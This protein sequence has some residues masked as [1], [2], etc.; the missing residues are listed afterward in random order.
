MFIE[1]DVQLDVVHGVLKSI[2]YAGQNIQR[3]ADTHMHIIENADVEMEKAAEN[4]QKVDGRLQNL[5]KRSNTCCLWTII[6][7]ELAVIAFI[8]LWVF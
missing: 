8:I 5:I 2:K 3:E 7:L 6:F 1:Q 4:I